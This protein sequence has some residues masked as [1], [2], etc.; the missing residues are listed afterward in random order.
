MTQDRLSAEHHAVARHLAGR[1]YRV[2]IIYAKGG[3]RVRNPDMTKPPFVD[4]N[5]FISFRKALVLFTNNRR[6]Q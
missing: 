3:F 2:T 1:G 4:H 5:G 6:F